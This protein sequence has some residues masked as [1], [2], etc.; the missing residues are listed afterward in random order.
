MIAEVAGTERVWEHTY[1]TD[2]RALLPDRDTGRGTR[3]EAERFIVHPNEIKGLRPGEAVLITKLPRA[4]AERVEVTPRGG[5]AGT[6]RPPP[7]REGP[8]MES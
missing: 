4:R 8:A 7:R 6:R 3:R 5:R 1:H 2:R